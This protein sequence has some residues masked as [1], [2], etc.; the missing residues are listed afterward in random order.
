M[1]GMSGRVRYANNS[2]EYI[3]MHTTQQAL[4]QAATLQIA[5]CSRQNPLPA[6]TSQPPSK[7][8]NSILSLQQIHPNPSKCAH[9]P[10]RIFVFIPIIPFKKELSQKFRIPILNDSNPSPVHQA[11]QEGYIMHSKK[12]RSDSLLGNQVV[13]ISFCDTKASTCV[14]V[15]ALGS[16]GV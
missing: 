7:Y 10:S 9:C 2:R 15:I 5:S 1:I 11:Q 13:N 4:T 16:R 8:S 6:P 3:A 14:T 12:V